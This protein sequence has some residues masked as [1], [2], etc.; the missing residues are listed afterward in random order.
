MSDESKKVP[1]NE[2]NMKMSRFRKE[3]DRTQ[4][5]WELVALFGKINLYYFTGTMQEGVLLIPR[6][7]DA[8]LWVRRSFDRAM[9]ESLFPQIRP[10]ESYRD[11]VGTVKLPETC[12]IE[13]E[14]IPIAFLQRFQKY[15][16]FKNIKSADKQIS[17]TR[18]IKSSYEISLMEKSG[19]KHRYVLEECVPRIL[20]RGMSEVDLVTELYSVM[21]RE[22]H[23]G[24]ARFAMFETDIGIGQIGFGDSSIYP[25]FFNG[26]GGNR[27]IS[28]AVPI[29]GSREREL[30]KGDLVFIDV[31]F[32]VDGYHT[33]KTMTY[34]FGRPL[35]ESAISQH[36]KCVEIQNNIAEMLKPGSIP[37]EI[38]KTI[39][40]GLDSEFADSFMGYNNRKVRFLGHGIGL[41]IDEYPVIAEG[42]TEPLELGMAIAVEPKIGI[43][44]IGMVGIE[45]TFLVTEK[46]GRCITGDN[47][48]LIGVY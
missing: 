7:N 5:E 26:P 9:D 17:R 27:G 44:G 34:M 3:M 16:P 15:F 20:R 23:H 11:I 4:P 13:A 18:S 39:M 45:N 35:P 47:P 29:I 28:P 36:K 31:G 1:L 25:T 42:F 21:V 30:E 2:L 43:E 10:M 40:E 14:I 19:A 12:H 32:G 37:A 22:G 24:V 38:Y 41:H 6:D 48:G 8:T 33:D 46:G